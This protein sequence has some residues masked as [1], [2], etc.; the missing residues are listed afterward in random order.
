MNKTTRTRN[1]PLD[2]RVT[3]SSETLMELLDC[4]RKTAVDIGNSAH[5]RVEIKRRVLWDVDK[6][7]KFI[8][9]EAL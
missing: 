5:A 2:Q 6:V 1:L 8:N 7:R 9:N 3:V 4:G